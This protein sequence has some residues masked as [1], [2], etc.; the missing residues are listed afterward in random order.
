[1][2]GYNWEDDLRG[3]MGNVK[4][5]CHINY[6]GCVNINKKFGKMNLRKFLLNWL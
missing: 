5:K 1:M 4:G 6:S 3:E 2:A